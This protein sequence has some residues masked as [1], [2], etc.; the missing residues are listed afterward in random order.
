MPGRPGAHTLTGEE[1][2]PEGRFLLVSD[3]RANYDPITTGWMLRK[4]D[5]AFISKPENMSIPIAGPFVRRIYYLPIDRQNPRRAIETIN[6]AADL[7]SQNVASIGVYPEGTR[8]HSTQML[9]FH[10]GVFKIAQKS[11]APIVVLSV[12]GTE[13][14]CKNFPWRRTDV[15]LKVCRVIDAE[16]VKVSSTAELGDMVRTSLEESLGLVTTKS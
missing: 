12:D 2:L 14:V 10:N 1:L 15:A 16:T 4:W 7:I 8:S 9:P 3:H 11:G 5:I 6:A 13:Q